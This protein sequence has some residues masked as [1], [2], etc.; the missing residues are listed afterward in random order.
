MLEWWSLT[1]DGPVFQESVNAQDIGSFFSDH[2]AD[3]EPTSIYRAKTIGRVRPDY[4]LSFVDV[5]L[6]PVLEE[7]MG[8]ELARLLK[9]MLDALYERLDGPDIDCDTGRWLFKSAFWLLAGKILKDKGVRRFVMLDMADVESVLGVVAKHYGA[10]ET[11]NP[12][13]AKQRRALEAAASIASG[14][15]SLANLTVESLAYV[16]ENSLIDKQTRTALGIHATPSYLADYVVWQLF[17]WI[18]EIPENDR[19]VLEPTCG[20]APFLVSAARLLRELMGNQDAQER[21]AYLKKHLLGI[22]VDPFAREIARLSLTLA[23]IPNPNGWRL[24]ACD[25]YSGQRLSKLA[26]KSTILLCNPPFQN[27][28]SQEKGQYAGI[29]YNN[30]AAELLARSL[31][32]M[33]DGSVFGVVVPRGF[34][35]SRNAGAVR[36]LLVDDCEIREVCTLP[37]KVFASADH[38]SAVILGRKN[39]IKGNLTKFVW[40]REKTL[41]RFKNSYD[42][43]QEIVGQSL[44]RSGEYQLFIPELRSVWDYCG[45]LPHLDSVTGIGQGLS[46][47]K[48]DLAEGAR[49]IGDRKFTRAVLGYT[50]FDSGMKLTETPASKYMCLDAGV[51]GRRRWGATVGTPQILMNYAPASRGPWRIKALVDEKGCPVTSSFLVARP[52]HEKL[53]L[54]ILWAILN[55]PMS[56]AYAYCHSTKRSILAGAM[57]ELP[58]PGRSFEEMGRLKSLVRKYFDLYTHNGAVLKRN[59]D[60]KEAERCMLAIDAE[61]MR[62]YDLPPILEKRVLDLFGGWKRPGVDFEFTGYYPEGFESA[63][64]LHEYLSEE[65]QRSTVGFVKDWIEKVRS[66]ELIEAFEK[67]AEA[68]EE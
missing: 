39:L 11:L 55:S 57:R 53:S 8:Q 43:P 14:F 15:S 20:H 58:L 41:S 18:R 50:Q 13:N 47:K 5:G 19:Y 16:Y 12:K 38:E 49:T 32:Y 23:D 45:S 60:C 34:L 66:P 35:T 36:R 62:L 46:Y 67:A 25:V 56:N 27:F 21:H 1:A 22:E 51:I 68:F 24:D 6:M 40:V 64:P 37:D 31:Q 2:G 3:F 44:L 65:Y 10:E 42:A 48:Q 30:K 17:D 9:R 29:Q 59:V 7:R 28:K 54:E 63:I 4:Q 26:A 33:P 52:R 61:V